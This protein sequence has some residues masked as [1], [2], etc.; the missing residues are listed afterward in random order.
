MIISE[1]QQYILEYCVDDDMG[2]WVVI[3]NVFGDAYSDT[4]LLPAWVQETALSE[5]KDLLKKGLIQIG[6][7]V[8]EDKDWVFIVFPGGDE[9]VIQK[10]KED[11]NNLER[12]PSGGDVCWIRSTEKG[13]ELAR[14]LGLEP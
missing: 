13:L 6:Q 12:N 1:L 14:Q 11:W 2:L 10:V 5:L 9:E 4:D 8:H 3:V 7:H